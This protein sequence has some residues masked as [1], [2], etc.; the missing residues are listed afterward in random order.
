MS[1]SETVGGGITHLL[2]KI[3]HEDIAQ[4]R[5]K[6]GYR[7]PESRTAGPSCCSKALDLLVDFS[8]SASSSVSGSFNSDYSMAAPTNLT[9]VQGT[10]GARTSRC[11]RGSPQS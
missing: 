4:L 9:M 2:R 1:G 8:E 10:C 6:P 5:V 7:Y 11:F 3:G